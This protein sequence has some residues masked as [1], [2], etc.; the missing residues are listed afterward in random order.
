MFVAELQQNNKY[1]CLRADR[2]IIVSYLL[3]L[4]RDFGTTGHYLDIAAFVMFDAAESSSTDGP[5]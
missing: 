2:N 5:V 4:S 3:F 1:R